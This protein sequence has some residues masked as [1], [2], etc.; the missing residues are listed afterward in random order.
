MDRFQNT[1]QPDWDWWGKLWP[2]PGER[3]RQLGLESGD[4]FAEIGCGTSYFA[5]PAALITDPA[6]VYGV[7]IDDS[8]LEILSDLADAQEIDNIDPIH[9]DARELGEHLSEPVD[10][11]LIANTFHG[12]DDPEAFAEQV[13]AVLADDG[14]FVVINWQDLPKEE[15]TVG[16]QVRGPPIEL[17]LSPDETQSIVEDATELTLTEHVEL[18]PYHYGLIFE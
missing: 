8:Y 15:T 10:V 12:I 18:P 11:G 9:G 4:T 13:V 5:I 1:K 2:S 7:D 6:P 17:R 3:L 16:G 14:Q